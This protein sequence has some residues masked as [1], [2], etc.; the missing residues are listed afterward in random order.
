MQ[1]NHSQRLSETPLKTWSLI[2]EDEEVITVHCNC[3]AGCVCKN[4]NKHEEL[5][6]VSKLSI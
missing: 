2:K 4:M 5:K 6:M 3:M 1:V